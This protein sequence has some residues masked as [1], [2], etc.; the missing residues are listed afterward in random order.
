MTVGL[1]ELLLYVCLR[2]HNHST[3]ETYFQTFYRCICSMQCV[4]GTI[5]TFRII[6]LFKFTGNPH[7]KRARQKEGIKQKQQ[8][9]NVFLA[10]GRAFRIQN[11]FGH[12]FF[13]PKFAKQ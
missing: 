3:K 4:E 6:G 13:P 8:L 12:N 7:K 5:I 1:R 2:F 10:W 9:P 11:L